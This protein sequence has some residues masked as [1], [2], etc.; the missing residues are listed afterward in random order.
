MTKVRNTLIILIGILML[1]NICSA[2]T[3]NIEAP[4]GII[5]T[6]GGSVEYVITISDTEL[7]ID[8]RF[9][10]FVYPENA[11]YSDWAYEF[12]PQYILVPGVGSSSTILTIEVPLDTEA[13]TYQH[14][15]VMQGSIDDPEF[16]EFADFT[17]EVVQTDV[18][19]P[20]FPTVAMP[21]LAI[22]GIV[23]IFARRKSG[24]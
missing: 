19:V 9:D 2:I 20:E 6:P 10:F 24:L 14:N 1:T 15:V 12:K 16:V 7:P 3:Y 11:L 22:L 5:A 23:T 13:G 4:N 17:T 8:E 21:I 18:S